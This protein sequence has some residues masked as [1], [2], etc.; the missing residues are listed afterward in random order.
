MQPRRPVQV[1]PHPEA[2]PA[3]AADP[4][5]PR[6]VRLDHTCR[7]YLLHQTGHPRCLKDRTAESPRTV[8][9]AQSGSDSAAEILGPIDVGV[10]GKESLDSFPAI[11]RH[12]RPPAS[13]FVEVQVEVLPRRDRRPV[14]AGEGRVYAQPLYIAAHQE[15]CRLKDISKPALGEV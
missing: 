9:S 2:A 8:T 4:A 11:W 7:P 10:R 15:A 13:G 14:H 5:Q 12:W 3:V 1:P 6:H